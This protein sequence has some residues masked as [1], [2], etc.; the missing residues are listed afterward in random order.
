MKNP[1][2]DR[3]VFFMQKVLITGGS[4]PRGITLR[5]IIWLYLGCRLPNGVNLGCISNDASFELDEKLSE[6][7]NYLEPMVIAANKAGVERFACYSSSAAADVVAHRNRRA[8]LHPGYRTSMLKRKRIEEPF[9]WSKAIAGLRKTQ[10]RGR[11]PVEW[12]FIL[13]G[14]P[15]NLVRIPGMSLS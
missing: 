8:A 7:I 1:T 9:G 4:S 12:F 13:A 14:V 2:S 5:Y 10:R 15:Y 6:T 3:F 11:E